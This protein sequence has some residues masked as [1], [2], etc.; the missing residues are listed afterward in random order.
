MI[1]QPFVFIRCNGK[2]V[3]LALHE[4]LYLES[5]KNY[6]QVVTEQKSFLALI[7]LR[8]LEQE[9]PAEMFCRVHR[10]FIVAVNHVVAFDNDTVQVLQKQ[11]PISEQYR[12]ALPAR[13]TILGHEA[14]TKNPLS[15]VNVDS[16]L[17]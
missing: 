4:I 17:N 16:L 10:S 12:Q 13:V 9:L 14:R 5:K 11:I 15:N 6:V 8:Q 1:T 2:Y 3:R 7:T